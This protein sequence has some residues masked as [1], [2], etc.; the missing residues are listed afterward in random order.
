A[1]LAVLVV[2]AVAIAGAALVLLPDRATGPG[3]GG[4]ATTSTTTS[5]ASD[6]T[7]QQQT[8]R[9]GATLSPC[10]RGDAERLTVLSLNVHSGRTKAG[11]LDLGRI[12]AE[13][14][15]W[16]A[17]LVLLQEVDQGRR[18]THGVDQPRRLA[19]RL[20]YSHVYGPTRRFR[21]G[22]TGNAILS[23]WP[24]VDV[25]LRHLP[26]GSGAYRR[27]LVRATVDV[28]GQQV[29]VFSTHFDH[30]SRHARRAQARVVAASV[31]RSSWPVV[32]GGDLN[33]EPGMPA[34]RVLELAGLVDGWSL[35]GRDEGLTVPA[36]SP[37]RRIDYVLA[38]ESFVPVRS[39]VLVSFVSDHRGVMT[40]YDLL[41]QR[42]Q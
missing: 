19:R 22:S 33:A 41:P 12:A 40:T 28:H 42:C 34:V 36:A 27:G 7:P 11:T 23:R 29:D 18:R 38:D 10:P 21:P 32:L 2:T 31:R 3:L 39:R 35:V 26:R 13:L 5:D 14:R 6:V 37:H 8:T 9:T 16:D 15:A 1:L 4:P 30:A 24:V 20:G 25:G 17:D